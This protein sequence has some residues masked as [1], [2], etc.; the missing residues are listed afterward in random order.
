[1]QNGN[2]ADC[3]HLKNTELDETAGTTNNRRAHSNYPSNSDRHEGSTNTR[4]QTHR[5]HV[6]GGEPWPARPRQTRGGRANG[7]Y[8]VFV[9]PCRGTPQKDY[10]STVSGGTSTLNAAKHTS[11]RALSVPQCLSSKVQPKTVLFLD[12]PPPLPSPPPI[13]S[14]VF[15]QRVF[16]SGSVDNSALDIKARRYVQIRTKAHRPFWPLL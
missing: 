14:L 11:V 2:T 9:Q 6:L 1:M 13:L 3:S 10:R 15:S 8:P 4:T 5:V 12:P 16:P 7:Q